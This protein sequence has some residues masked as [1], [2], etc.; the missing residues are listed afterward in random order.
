MSATV[1][2]D[3][4]GDF[5]LDDCGN[6]KIATGD[7]CFLQRI[8]RRLLTTPR[9]FDAT[10]QLPIGI[11]DYIFNVTFGAGLRR[12][13]DS[14]ANLT[15]IKRVVNAQ[16]L[17]DPETSRHVRPVVEIFNDPSTPSNVLSMAITVVRAG[18][19][20]ITFS[21]KITGLAAESM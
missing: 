16:I 19:S 21:L 13:V 9:L 7:R 10:T 1:D 18:S 20:S 6:T 2:L 8:I 14:I 5:V 17:A 12:I 3:W 4:Q 11:P 15:E